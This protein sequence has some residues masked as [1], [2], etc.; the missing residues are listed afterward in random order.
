MALWPDHFAEVEGRP[1]RLRGAQIPDA[2]AEE[3]VED[4]HGI[5]GNGAADGSELDWFAVAS[6]H[7]GA[8]VAPQLRDFGG[9]LGFVGDF[10]GEAALLVRDVEGEELLGERADVPG[11]KE[12]RGVFGDDVAKEVVL[13]VRVVHARVASHGEGVLRVG[14]GEEELLHARDGEQ[15]ESGF[16]PPDES[17][18]ERQGE[19]GQSGHEVARAGGVAA[20][21]AVEAGVHEEEPGEDREPE[22]RLGGEGFPMEP[23]EP[24]DETAKQHRRKPE[25]AAIRR[26]RQQPGDIARWRAKHAERAAGILE[27]RVL[28]I[29][30]QSEGRAEIYRVI[31]AEQQRREQSAEREKHRPPPMHRPRREQRVE[32]QRDDR[33]ARDVIRDHG[34]SRAESRECRPRSERAQ[35]IEAREEQG[36]GEVVVKEQRSKREERGAEC[37]RERG[38]QRRR[39]RS[40]GQVAGQPEKDHAPERGEESDAEDGG[41]P[42]VEIHGPPVVG[43]N[44][45]R[46]FEMEDREVGG[47]REEGRAGRLVRMEMAGVRDVG[48]IA[49]SARRVH[50]L[51]DRCRFGGAPIDR[52]IDP[53]PIDSGHPAQGVALSAE[54]VLRVI[55]RQAHEV[56]RRR[57]ALIDEKVINR[58]PPLFDHRAHL[59]E[60]GVLIPTA[61]L[62]EIREHEKRREEQDEFETGD[63]GHWGNDE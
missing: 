14:R 7:G 18:D 4:V 40:S 45:K 23:K 27:D 63:A 49:R 54:V 60:A 22:A 39:F 33:P 26:H 30:G 42:R 34:E 11:E 44:A 53:L 6:I 12:W 62:M 32:S 19:E 21:V 56:V 2:V 51:L 36:G 17:D 9:A 1:V 61:A 55:Q 50:G 3:T 48:H 10:R 43:R 38:E 47:Q 16:F 58:E 31:P 29:V 24:A 5:D 15:D 46:A 28:E 59:G 52:V 37:Q 57:V 13:A 41:Q 8:C 35:Q 20:V 25:D